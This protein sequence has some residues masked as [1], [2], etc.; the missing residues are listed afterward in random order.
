M[1]DTIL[2]A[3]VAVAHIY[4]GWW[5]NKWY[6]KRLDKLEE[7]LI[8][9]RGMEFSEWKRTFWSFLM[10][11]FWWFVLFYESVTNF[12]QWE[13]PHC[14]PNYKRLGKTKKRKVKLV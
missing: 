3:I 7:E 14:D 4:I 2:I 5:T 12:K 10:V 6:Q 13:Y 8:K 1:I 11:F 9:D